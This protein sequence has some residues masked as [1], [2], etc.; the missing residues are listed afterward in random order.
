MIKTDQEKLHE[1]TKNSIKNMNEIRQRKDTQN[2]SS[3]ELRRLG[4]RKCP[5]CKNHIKKEQM[6]S[7]QWNKS[8]IKICFDCEIKGPA[9]IGVGRQS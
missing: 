8:K 7:P 9:S 3:L 5:V 1:A 6:V 4:Y 2:K